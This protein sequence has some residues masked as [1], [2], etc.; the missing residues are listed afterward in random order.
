VRKYRDFAFRGSSIFCRPWA[1][2]LL[3]T[4]AALDDALSDGWR[5]AIHTEDLSLVSAFWGGIKDSGQGAK[6]D[7]RFRR[8]DG[9]YR[10]FSVSTHPFQDGGD[11]HWCWS[12]SYADEGRAT[13]GRLRRLFDTLPIQAAFLNVAGV[14]KFCNVRALTDFGMTFEQLADPNSSGI[15]HRGDMPVVERSRAP[16]GDGG[17]ARRRG[18]FFVSGRYLSMDASAVRPHL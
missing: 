10:W 18:S 16:N 1:R 6:I 12:A 8:F 7:V 4:G 13:D 2:G 17:M 11:S 9:E 15:L 3:G 14:L 5:A